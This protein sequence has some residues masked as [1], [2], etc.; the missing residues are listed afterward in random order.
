MHK[1]V[2]SVFAAIAVLTTCF[3]GCE[4]KPEEAS[5]DGLKI[6]S[7][8]FPEYD[9]V[10][11]IMGDKA[12]GAELT[13][14]IDSG[15]DLHSF[16]PTADDL[17]KI[18]EC[19]LFIYVG[20]ESDEWVESALE[21]VQN[22]DRVV[23]NLCEVLDDMLLEEEVAEGMEEHDHEHE[24]DEDHDD[25]DE[26]DEHDEDEHEHEHEN[27][28]H[29]WLS[30]KNAQVACKA[31]SEKLAA[32]DSENADSYKANCDEY[33]GKLSA[34]DGEYKAAVDAGKTKTLLFG[35]RFP[36]LY[37]VKDYG[38]TYYAAFSG[39]SAETE[40][41]FETITFLA[42]KADETGVP[43]IITIE[44]SQHKIAQTIAENCKD[45][46][47]EIVTLNSLQSVTAKEIEDGADYLSI[48]KENL[49]VLK[50]ALG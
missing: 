12:Q 48:M 9:W 39:C 31:I 22:P 32:I 27:D 41:S 42:N 20:G 35:D 3:A 33:C 19:D 45:K 28:E 5:G 7:T 30:L 8:I 37:M 50:K 34:L 14:L 2:I 43:C 4:A 49:E 18:S 11:N 25:E 36:F 40:A 21:S 47:K 16:Q 38:L 46:N 17:I 15:V 6:V 29:I 24:H 44:G 1:K 23:I 13:V 10:K 26:H